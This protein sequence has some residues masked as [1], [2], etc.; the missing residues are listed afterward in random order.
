MGYVFNFL[1]VKL[2]FM[3]VCKAEV[4]IIPSMNCLDKGY[5]CQS[6]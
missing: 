5:E 3:A 1:V 2:L 4:E 6:S